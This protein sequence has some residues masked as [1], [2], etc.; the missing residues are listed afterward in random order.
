MET[1][2]KTVQPEFNVFKALGV[3]EADKVLDDIFRDGK[4]DMSYNVL[5]TAA[6]QGTLPT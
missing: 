6:K 1:T 5:R 2:T 4:S 3:I